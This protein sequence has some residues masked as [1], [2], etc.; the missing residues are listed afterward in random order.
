L[1]NTQTSQGQEIFW[2]TWFLLLWF[3]CLVG[4]SLPSDLHD[5]LI[6]IRSKIHSKNES[7]VYFLSVFIRVLLRR[8]WTFR[9]AA[10][11]KSYIVLYCIVTK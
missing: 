3:S 4:Y 11:Y 9:R 7:S 10:P 2:R 6:L 1:L 8:S 5:L